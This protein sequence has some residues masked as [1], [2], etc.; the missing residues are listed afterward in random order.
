MS[1]NALYAKKIAQRMSAANYARSSAAAR[2]AAAGVGGVNRPS[3]TRRRST[4]YSPWSE[5]HA[6]A[7]HDR[8]CRHTKKSGVSRER[9]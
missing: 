3:R 2:T 5:P 9:S 1:T 7:C 4:A 6:S 8:S